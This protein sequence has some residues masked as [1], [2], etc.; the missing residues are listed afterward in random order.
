MILPH[1]LAL[2]ALQGTLAGE[3]ESK[4]LTAAA[5]AKSVAAA[6]EPVLARRRLA[7]LALA[8][9]K[10]EDVAFAT[11]GIRDAGGEPVTPDSMFYVASCTKTFT[12]LLIEKLAEADELELDDPL[13]TVLPQFALADEDAAASLTL[14]DLLCHRPG[15]NSS[16]VVL[17][18]AYSGEITDER[19]F[20]LLAR[21]KPAGEC[22]YSNTHFTLA[23][24]A[25]E[26]VHGGK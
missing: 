1:L 24:R 23:A 18:D 5:A 9:V 19:F 26:A 6:T 10:G 4:G 12:A 3:Q 21:E 22:G 17:L 25:A 16:P 14:R 20:R 11:L 15:L 7:G 2:H 8:V 13:R